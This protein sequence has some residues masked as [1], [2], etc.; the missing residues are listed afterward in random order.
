MA[1]FAGE[2]DIGDGRVEKEVDGGGAERLAELKASAGSTGPVGRHPA[3][4][5]D[6]RATRG[7]H[8]LCVVREAWV[9][10]VGGG[11][12]QGGWVGLASSAGRERRGA[13]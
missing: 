8:G 5:V 12:R 6:V 1:D 10:C 7:G 3:G 2:A 13:A 4:F 9:Q 11:D